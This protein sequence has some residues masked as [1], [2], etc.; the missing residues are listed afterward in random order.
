LRQTQSNDPEEAHTAPTLR[1]FFTT[2]IARN[3]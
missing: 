2:N 1:P 3:F